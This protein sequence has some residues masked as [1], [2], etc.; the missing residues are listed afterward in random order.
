MQ[1]ITGPSEATVFAKRHKITNGAMLTAG[2]LLFLAPNLVFATNFRGP[3]ALEVI[4]ATAIVGWLLIRRSRLHPSALLSLPTDCRMLAV[5]LCLGTALVLLAVLSIDRVRAGWDPP[6]SWPIG[7]GTSMGLAIV[8]AA[9]LAWG[10]YRANRVPDVIA[11]ELDATPPGTV[12][13]VDFVDFECPFCRALQAQLGP[14]LAAQ[15]DKI[16]VVRKLVP[17]TRIHPHALAAAKAACCGAQLGQGDAMAE[18]LFATKVEDLTADGCTK[19]AASLGLPLDAYRACVASPET[20]A[21]LAK[22]R[23]TFDRAAVKGDGLPLLWIGTH[24]LMGAQDDSTLSRVI[25]QAVA[26]IGS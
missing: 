2:A 1:S 19:V 18:A 7:L 12:T 5:C 14:K 15:G 3:I 8:A 16:R 26:G 4:A 23:E 24:K 20:D 10:V 9:P 17:L 13:V 25:Q 6:R 21:K 22:D 11:Q